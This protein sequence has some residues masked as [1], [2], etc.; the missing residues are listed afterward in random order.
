MKIN[1]VYGAMKSDFFRYCVLYK[2]GG[3]YLDIKSKIKV[4][5]FDLITDTDICLLDI[6]RSNLEFWRTNSPTYEQ[7]L[8][9]FTPK[10]PYLHY[11]I[12]QM[13]GYIETQFMPTIP[14]TPVLNSK[15]KIL[16]ITGPDAFAKVINEYNKKRNILH[17][18]IN[19]DDYFMRLGCSNYLQMYTVNNKK[20]YS[21]Y[22]DPLYI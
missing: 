1:P 7:W 18:C 11:M 20:H 6:P 5:P 3:V 13:V 2:I 17:R 21:E 22:N 4:N 10:H 12:K 14:N 19:Y 9:I 16:H 15:Q 8:L